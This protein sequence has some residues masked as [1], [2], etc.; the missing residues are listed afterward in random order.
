MALGWRT[1]TGGY[2]TEGRLV[3]QV[4]APLSPPSSFHAVTA[5]D[6]AEDAAPRSLLDW[7]A[8][9]GGEFD[10]LFLLNSSPPLP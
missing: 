6:R 5:F 8:S 1:I 7:L 9:L 3:V 4:E 10:E 2:V